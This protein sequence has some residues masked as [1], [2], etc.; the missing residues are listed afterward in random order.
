MALWDIAGRRYGVPVWMLLGGMLSK[1]FPMAA[2]IAVMPAPAMR[3]RV[4]ALRAD[5]YTQY[6][7]KLEG[8]TA[9]DLAR[10]AEAAAL[11]QPDETLTLDAN[12]GLSLLEATRIANAM[13]GTGVL[14]EQLCWGYEEMRALRG[15]TSL[16]FVLDECI[17][18]P[19]ELY[20]AAHEGVA[21]V[22]KIKLSRVGGVSAAK[23]IIDVCAACGIR[24]CVQECAGS[25][26]AGAAIAHLAA[27]TPPATLL[28]VWYPPAVND[29]VFAGTDAVLDRGAVRLAGTRPGLGVEPDMATLGAPIASCT[30]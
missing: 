3:E 17:V 22:I 6:S 24:T 10:A 18:T 23:H 27:A 14:L 5:G 20:R 26:I 19:R 9:E 8:D 7:A 30:L 4:L 16:P 28:G 2:S 29:C 11:I 1:A 15:R 25:E 13:E 12:R 21:D